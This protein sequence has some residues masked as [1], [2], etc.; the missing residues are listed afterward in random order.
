MLSPALVPSTRA[1]LSALAPFRLSAS[2][3]DERPNLLALMEWV[4][5]R[6]VAGSQ[7]N[8]AKAANISHSYW[9]Y[10]SYCTTGPW[11]GDRRV[12]S[13]TFGACIL[14]WDGGNSSMCS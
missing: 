1:V 3:C 7:F 5:T 4:P 14:G 9:H 13:E 8:A 6:L 12:P 10:S 2:R 11:F